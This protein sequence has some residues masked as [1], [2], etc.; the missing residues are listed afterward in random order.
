MGSDAN[1][2]IKLMVFCCSDNQRDVAI[3][4]GL[5]LAGF[6]VFVFEYS[7]FFILQLVAS[8]YKNIAPIHKRSVV[9]TLYTSV[10]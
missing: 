6:F 1:K 3:I 4:S 2:T 7:D 5:V 10:Q 8:K 9:F